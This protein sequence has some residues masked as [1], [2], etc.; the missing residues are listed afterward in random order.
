[1][2]TF[3]EQTVE[4]ISDSSVLFHHSREQPEVFYQIENTPL[5]QNIIGRP[6]ISVIIPSLNEAEN[7][8]HVLPH[9]PD[10][11]NEVILVDGRSTDDTIAIAQSILPNIKVVHQNGKGK[12]NA[13]R[14][15][16][17]ACT[18]DIIV[19]M[20]A[21]GSTDPQEISRFIE[22]LLAGADYVKGSRFVRQGGS[23]D[24][25]PLRNFGNFVLCS[26]V[27]RLF[28]VRFTD[29]CYGYNAFWKDCLDRFEVDCNGFEVEALMNVRACKA[30][31]NIVEVP[32]FEHPRIHGNSNLRTL[33]DGWRILRVIMR[34]WVNGRSVIKAADARY[35]DQQEDFI[36]DGQVIID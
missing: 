36:L 2:D 22:A 13:L 10:I 34:E 1:M 23:S 18:G 3:D 11:V 30:S 25:T 7:L 12:G 33:R 28:H 16:F 19:M 21:D 8:P 14:C 27:N 29:L 26:I 24:I 6:G 32:S 9:I 15:G 4:M 35:P 5:P 31:F 20:D 17:A